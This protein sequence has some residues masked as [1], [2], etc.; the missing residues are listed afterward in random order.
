MSD[1]DWKP[2]YGGLFACKKPRLHAETCLLHSQK[3]NSVHV[4]MPE[5]W[6]KGAAAIICA[7][8][9]EAYVR[10]DFDRY[11]QIEAL[12]KG[13]LVKKMRKKGVGI[14]EVVADNELL[15]EAVK[16]Y[17][18]AIMPGELFDDA[19]E[20]D[21]E[22]IDVSVEA[23]AQ[24]LEELAQDE[25]AHDANY[26]AMKEGFLLRNMVCPFC[27]YDLQAAIY[28]LPEKLGGGLFLFVRFA[29]EDQFFLV[30]ESHKPGEPPIWE[31][32]KCK[33][34]SPM[35]AAAAL[36]DYCR[37]RL[38]LDLPAFVGLSRSLVMDADNALAVWESA[39]GY[40]LN[41]CIDDMGFEEFAP[42][43]LFCERICE[44]Q[45]ESPELFP[46]TEMTRGEIREA[47]C[48]DMI[49]IKDITQAW[50]EQR[51]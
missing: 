3:T 5:T 42:F 29:P 49:E 30:D 41:A 2:T 50:V 9:G 51:L 11:Y 28:R 22:R 31:S 19:E 8:H 6:T 17:E 18:L 33:V 1:A 38:G 23:V 34:T 4:T 13:E 40:G 14:L 27:D 45:K 37:K 47:I 46:T 15:T 36:V 32:D 25:S 43:Q 20:E 44:V 12:D 48:N 10:A 39:E 16:V 24:K 26:Y 35:V 21:A 7:E